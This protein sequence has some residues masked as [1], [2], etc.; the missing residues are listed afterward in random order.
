V[1]SVS[2]LQVAS[3]VSTPRQQ[4]ASFGLEA[5]IRD[6]SSDDDSDGDNPL[7]R[8][9]SLV[10]PP[11]LLSSLRQ[12]HPSSS[13]PSM[14]SATSPVNVTTISPTLSSLALSHAS[15]SQPHKMAA[16]SQVS[17][18][19]TPST[20]RFQ[21]PPPV[22]TAAPNKSSFVTPTFTTASIVAPCH[23][24]STQGLTGGNSRTEEADE[25]DCS[26]VFKPMLPKQTSEM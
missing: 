6:N 14:D 12:R 8:P 9:L 15:L 11:S 26:P 2:S 7:P 22:I 10:Q 5:I 18:F 23:A 1:S 16:T 24:K 25:M 21:L 13:P 17:Q 20:F 3:P 19:T 4:K